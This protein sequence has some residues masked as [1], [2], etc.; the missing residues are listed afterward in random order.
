MR[1]EAAVKLVEDEGTLRFV[2]LTAALLIRVLGVAVAEVLDRVP[3]A[4]I[5][6]PAVIVQCPLGPATALAKVRTLAPAVA[7]N[8]PL[9]APAPVQLT[10][11]AM[12]AL[13]TS[14]AARLSVK[15][16]ILSALALEPLVMVSV[17][18]TACPA[19]TVPPAL[20]DCET[21]TGSLRFNVLLKAL[22]PRPRALPM[23]LDATEPV[24]D[25]PPDVTGAFRP[26]LKLQL[27][28][29][30]MV[31]PVNVMLVSPATTDEP[32]PPGELKVAPEH[33]VEADGVAAIAI[34][35]GNVWVR[36]VSGKLTLALGLFNVMVS[37][38]P[39]PT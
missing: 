33:V 35:A 16:V 1:P 7:V 20:L 4:F 21:D 14:P 27:P 37:V 28:P 25:P 17:N 5:E 19:R 18:V 34:P 10:L 26:T 9:L 6:T 31:P 36:L 3:A 12:P 11:G 29:P 30:A 15:L 8:V 32:A 2:G 13:N 39:S 38:V 23:P 22:L 24:T